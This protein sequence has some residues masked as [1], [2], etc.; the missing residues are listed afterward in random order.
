MAQPAI[1]PGERRRNVDDARYL[2]LAHDRERVVVDVAVAVVEGDRRQVIDRLAGEEA[3][4]DLVERHDLAVVAEPRELPLEGA[5]GDQQRRDRGG[6]RRVEG[7]D[8]TVV[9]QDDR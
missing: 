3:L 9:P 4:A 8:D 7:L 1:G 5:G 6:R 2:Q